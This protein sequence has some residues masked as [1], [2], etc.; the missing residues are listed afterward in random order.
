MPYDREFAQRVRDA[1]APIEVET[2]PMFGGLGFLMNGNMA[3]AVMGKGGFMMRVPPADV[4]SLV[5]PHVRPMEMR[6]RPMTGWV[7]VDDEAVPTDEDL[8]RFVRLAVETTAAVP[9][10]R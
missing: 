9:P 6:G 7:K 10:K 1:F 3:L 4:D 5:G 2:K 8:Q